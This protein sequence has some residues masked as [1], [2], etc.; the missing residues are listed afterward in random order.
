[1]PGTLLRYA[2]ALIMSVM[3]EGLAGPSPTRGPTPSE[4]AGALAPVPPAR[5]GPDAFEGG[6]L[7]DFE[8]APDGPV[9]DFYGDLGVTMVDIK[10]GRIFDTGTGAGDSWVACNFP[11]FQRIL[12]PGELLFDSPVR[13]VGFFVTTNDGDDVTVTAYLGDVPVGSELFD[14]GGGGLGGSFAGVEFAEPFDRVVID[15]ADNTNSF[16]CIDDL[17]FVE[18]GPPGLTVPIDIM[19]G[20]ATNPINPRSRGVTPVALLS[21]A[22]LDAPGEVDR[23]SLTFGPTGIEA[24]VNARGRAG[25]P[26]CG[27][28][29]VNGDGRSDLVCRFETAAAGFAAGDATGIVRGATRSG[30][31]L[32]GSDAVV[33][34]G[35]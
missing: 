34:R 35:N 4:L 6:A 7:V 1:M 26:A 24:P 18:A 16:F 33:V 23:A 14:T 15:P 27:V 30:L 32:S 8:T 21:T 22:E 10:S 2:P 11:P 29:D 28:R 19:P 5:V 20:G 9:G 31:A 3:V 25:R 13:R 12:P 17:R